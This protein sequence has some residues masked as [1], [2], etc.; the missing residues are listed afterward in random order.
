MPPRHER[1]QWLQLGGRLQGAEPGLLHAAL[2]GLLQHASLLDTTDARCKANGFE[3]VVESMKSLVS[4]TELEELNAARCVQLKKREGLDLKP[5]IDL[6]KSD[7]NL[8]IKADKTLDTILKTFE[9]RSTDQHDFD[10]LLSVMYHIIKGSSFD[11]LLSASAAN[12]TLHSIVTKL[13]FFNHGCCVQVSALQT[14][15][16]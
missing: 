1:V 13:L 7:V 16:T 4:G 11:L 10:N 14:C 12:G 8:T 2:T 5:P 15:R 9:N 6:Q 3:L